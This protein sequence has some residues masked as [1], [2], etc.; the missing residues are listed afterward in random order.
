MDNNKSYRINTKINEDKVI[1]VKLEQDV[2]FLEILS[3]ELPQSNAYR[4]HT[5]NYGVLVGRAL[6]NDS[7]G[8]QNAKISIFVE[9]TDAD[10]QNS[11][12]TNI[13]P[14]TSVSSENKNNIRYNL[15]PSE[16]NDNCYK[17]I[18]TF[19]SKRLVLDDKTELEI[20]EKYWKFTTV[21]NKSGDYCIYGIPTGQNM[22]HVDLDLS[23]CGILSQ[24]PRDFIY[25]GH[26]ITEFDNANQFKDSTNLDNLAQ[27]ISQDQSVFIYPFWGDNSVNEVAITRSDIKINYKFEP[28]CVFIG[29]I[30][31][32]TKTISVGHDCNPSKENGYNRNLVAGEG[33]IEMIRKTSDGFVE[34]FQIQGNRLIDS[35]GV[36]CYQIPMNLDYVGTDEYGNIIPVD[37]SNKG[38]PTRTKVRFRFSIDDN[39]NDGFSRH[40][41][42]YLVP[43]NPILKDENTDINEN[44]TNPK[45][46]DY[47]TFGTDTPDNCF[48]DLFWNKVYS[49]KNYIPRVQKGNKNARNKRYIG[50]RTTNYHGSVNPFPYNNLRFHLSFTYRII[51]ILTKILVNVMKVLNAVITVID[52]IIE[53]IASISLLG[54]RPFKGLRNIEMACVE[55]SIDDAETNCNNTGYFPGCNGAAKSATKRKTGKTVVSST[56]TLNAK[57]EQLLA[58]ENEV[59]NLDFYNDWINGTLYMP[60][61]W[62]KK[63]T[64]KNYFF[65]LIHKKGINSY[66]SCDASKNTYLILPCADYHDKNG[67]ARD[68]TKEGNSKEG[69]NWHDSDA[70]VV[71]V[72]LNHGIIQNIENKAGL[73]LY[74]YANGIKN[75][76]SEY[77]RLFANDII[78]LGSLLD[79]DL[80]GIPQLYSRLPSTTHNEVPFN[81]DE[82][83]ECYDSTHS[84]SSV[85]EA[86]TGYDVIS[87]SNGDSLAVSGNG[88]FMDIGCSTLNT[89]HKTC[90]N[91]SRLCELGVSRDMEYIDNILTSNGF[92]TGIT[93]SDGMI[94]R[95]ELVDNDARAMF[96]TMNHN[97]LNKE[98]IDKNTG[99]YVYDLKYMYP[100][101]FDA[102]LKLSSQA[103]TKK[104]KRITYDLYNP[105]YAMFRYG[106]DK[107]KMNTK[108]YADNFFPLYNNSFYFYFGFKEG[109][110]ALDKFNELFTAICYKNK[111]EPFNIYIST[112]AASSC[113]SV[114]AQDNLL[115]LVNVTF[116]KIDKPYYYTILDENSNE[117]ISN[118]K[119][120]S[121]E[122]IFTHYFDINGINGYTITN[123]KQHKII[124]SEYYIKIIDGKG[125]SVTQY[126]N[127][128]QNPINLSF[129]TNDLG[130]HSTGIND[131]D[132][133]KNTYNSG[134]ITLSGITID[135]VYDTISSVVYISNGRYD[136]KTINGYEAH[137]VVSIPNGSMFN[138]E[139]INSFSQCICSNNF[140][141]NNNGS[142]S[143]NIKV[144]IKY[145]L[146][147]IQLCDGSENLQNTNL[148]YASIDNGENF[149][150]YINNM[151]F[152]FMK[153]TLYNS[154]SI[155]KWTS[156]EN[157]SNYTMNNFPIDTNLKDWVNW[158]NISVTANT[159]DTAVTGFT[160]DTYRNMIIFKLNTLFNLCDGLYITEN[161]YDYLSITTTGGKSPIMIN[162]FFPQYDLVDTTTTTATPLNQ[163]T[164][165]SSNSYINCLNY[166]NIIGNNY[167]YRVIE[168]YF[169]NIL[170]GSTTFK[171][172]PLIDKTTNQGNYI[173]AL[174]NNGGL[175][176]SNTGCTTSTTDY[177]FAYP[178]GI[179]PNPYTNHCISG[180]LT[181]LTISSGNKKVY[182]VDGNFTNY[183]RALFV[184]RRLDYD[185]IVFTSCEDM[186]NFKSD[187]GSIDW[188]LAKMSG[189]TYNGID[190]AYQYD[191]NDI[192]YNYN[193][194]AT[195]NTDSNTANSEYYYDE[196][197]GN[198]YST[199]ST[200]RKLYS[201]TIN[202]NINVLSN[203]E[204]VYTSYP[205][206]RKLVYDKITSGNKSLSYTVID[207]SYGIECGENI[208]DASL[209]KAKI[210][211]KTL[212]GD[213]V[214]FTVNNGRNIVFAADNLYEAAAYSGDGN[215]S[216]GATTT[217]AGWMELQYTTSDGT[218]GI[219]Y[220]ITAVNSFIKILVDEYDYN[221]SVRPKVPVL[222]PFNPS[223]STTDNKILKLK[224]LE[225]INLGYKNNDM[226]QGRI[227]GSSIDSMLYG[228]KNVNTEDDGNSKITNSNFGA[229]AITFC[230]AWTSGGKHWRGTWPAR[231]YDSW[232]KNISEYQDFGLGKDYT[233]NT[234]LMKNNEKNDGKRDIWI[235]KNCYFSEKQFNY[236]V[237][238]D[239]DGYDINDG[240]I[241][242]P[243]DDSDPMIT[244][245]YIWRKY[246]VSNND[247][248]ATSIPLNG[249]G[250]F[251]IIVDSQYDNNTGDNL[252]K[253]VRVINCSNLF[254][255]RPV[256][257]AID[258][259]SGSKCAFKLYY[260]N[261]SSFKDIDTLE[262]V[263]YIRD[264][265]GEANDVTIDS[266][267]GS[268]YIILNVNL[269]TYTI[270]NIL[271]STIGLFI[272]VTGGLK[273]GFKFQ[274]TSST[275]I[276]GVSYDSEFTNLGS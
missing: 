120:S 176:E 62:W 39:E 9:L 202:D 182:N 119:S 206:R 142:Y 85:I 216:N 250:C 223:D 104:L 101:D 125:K 185:F 25:K 35:N 274:F 83:D 49:V 158:I 68:D 251:A 192:E 159:S 98:I 141:K 252:K 82:V 126:F 221:H 209:N 168:E 147:L 240:T 195:S 27:V 268:T 222:L 225:T 208:I 170:T 34:E 253:S 254:D 150:L 118:I 266:G 94:T 59:V 199:N 149:Y 247:G 122:L 204:N 138:G 54:W 10:R 53:S 177:Y 93:Q 77:Y 1:N 157:V 249:Y 11:E 237:S 7:F 105:Y 264:D 269:G 235:P 189:I 61:W 273:W 41:A 65:G 124:N 131:S 220:T 100:T 153:D 144:P 191:E 196:S 224:T 148:F 161:G 245:S 5:S 210:Y 12:I 173:G 201:A 241:G 47:Y 165:T 3:L 13:Y 267:D 140:Y 183:M 172:N 167:Q 166:P 115:G 102:S 107:G 69:T 128:F 67:T 234:C 28:T 271:N 45:L 151:P 139:I 217:N 272:K 96:A 229:D 37:N 108:M 164:F 95:F 179:N 154:T 64:K 89:F 219:T 71:G 21:T 43:N 244:S 233:I 175:I 207:C 52:T 178:L 75:D 146:T 33:T 32:D 66:C 213:V 56:D 48:R 169:D 246:H 114:L 133:C 160:Y 76:N 29:S 184:D 261:N 127:I 24:R 36:W 135:D 255:V 238:T 211:T 152:Q 16:S 55:F 38:I 187:N 123:D 87:T 226:T 239:S 193:I 44:N 263:F 116:D 203:L 22:V 26:N 248:V 259:A 137:L 97:G 14:Y 78:L 231:R 86:I 129:S 81:R 110:T 50:I 8:V 18:G 99:Y 92:R 70:H 113:Y 181:K 232:A 90:I 112:T 74:Y 174:T 200:N 103:Y 163:Y 132:V 57:V 145:E 40:R 218:N 72:K 258:S 73:N 17:V 257:L 84:T 260:G 276:T 256:E 20:Y 136:I 19:P 15:F 23:D 130:I 91:A 80:N 186:P 243:I 121:S 197:N 117:I 242:R 188:K 155:D 215:G 60:L 51:C 275:K 194:I 162:S 63:T 2:S 227:T 31:T 214:N 4:L 156:L 143:I 265:N 109:A 46:I 6:A 190:M 111:K 236:F 88:Y 58:Q 198:I 171:L 42:K 212:P 230:N 79:C 205:K 270:D 180:D 30:I 106:T 228:E 262:A 134:Q